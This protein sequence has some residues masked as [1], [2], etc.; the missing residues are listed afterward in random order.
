[1]RLS[2]YAVLLLRHWL[3]VLGGLVLGLGLA[4][5]YLMTAD[6]EYTARTSLLVTPIT[7]AVQEIPGQRSATEINLDTEAQ[8]VTSAETAAAAAAALGLTD[9]EAAGLAAGVSV[10]V[11]PNSEI[12]DIAVNSE[13]A[14]HARRGAQA[15]AQAYLDRRQATAQAA[16]AGQVQGLQTRIDSLNQQLQDVTRLGASLEAGSAELALIL[17]QVAGLT[18]QLANLNSLQS[19]A[20]SVSVSPGRIVTP[21]ALPTAP[22]SPDTLIALTAGGALG[23]LAG[24]G[25]AAWGHRRDDLLRGIG[26]LRRRTSVPVAATV[27]TSLHVDETVLVD[28]S[29]ADGRAYARMRNLVTSSLED[30]ARRVVLVAGVRRGGGPVAVNL[31]ASLARA[32]EDVYLLCGDAATVRSLVGE[33]PPG[34]LADTRPP[35]PSPQAAAYCVPAV[36]NLRVLALG[37]DTD[38]ASALASTRGLKDVIAVLSAT[39]YVVIEAPPMTDSPDAQT[40]APV[41][42]VV[43]LVVETGRTRAREISDAVAEFRSVHVPVLGAVVVRYRT[44]RLSAGDQPTPTRPR[45]GDQRSRPSRR[46]ARW[47]TGSHP[48]VTRPLPEPDQPVGSAVGDHTG[49]TGSAGPAPAQEPSLTRGKHR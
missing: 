19:Q 46:L 48:N 4:V 22:T 24:V 9:D 45:W 8:L 31:A 25:A 17:D 42:G 6:T 23:L 49:T 44:D 35:R 47:W 20:A 13:T 26:D 27:P 36:P 28:A 40:L 21:A 11:P 33:Q 29:A 5:G 34:S 38:H 3:A 2:D 16:L 32:G 43:V 39:A 37:R 12:L 14:E 10:T 1:M 18:N 41:A 15:V 30:S 7:T